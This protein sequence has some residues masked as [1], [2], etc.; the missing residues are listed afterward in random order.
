MYKT[1]EKESAAEM[2]CGLREEGPTNR[3]A[4]TQNVEEGE[5]R[6]GSG[7]SW[8]THTRY[9]KVVV[10]ME[11]ERYVEFGKNETL[12]ALQVLDV[13]HNADSIFKSLGVQVSSV[14]LVIWTENNF[15][16]A[17]ESLVSIL[18][19]FNTWRKDILAP[20]LRHDILPTYLCIN[21]S[22]LWE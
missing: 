13:I 4:M 15:I 22:Q 14:G 10:V 17:G 19:D 11:H 2:W 9:A 7:P 20:H 16:P 21:R 5:G 18:E 1:D 3:E 6:S 12:V 8:W